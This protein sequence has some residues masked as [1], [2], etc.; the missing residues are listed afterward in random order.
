MPPICTSKNS[1]FTE[2]LVRVERNTVLSDTV[3][4]ILGEHSELE[5]CCLE[6]CDG[7]QT[8]DRELGSDLGINDLAS[9]KADHIIHRDLGELCCII[10]DVRA[11]SLNLDTEVSVILHP[12]G[13]FV[14]LVTG[15]HVCDNCVCH[16]STY[17]CIDLKI[18]NAGSSK[19]I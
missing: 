16:V 10:L 9:C 1:K 5:P 17:H 6:N 15:L 13:D 2:I 3:D 7:S 11:I 14:G 8:R 12:N 18:Y 19:V 4:E